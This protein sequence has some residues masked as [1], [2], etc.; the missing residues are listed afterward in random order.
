MD[1]NVVLR[2][3]DHVLHAVFLPVDID[4]LHDR[5]WR[6]QDYV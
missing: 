2:N 1:S 3:L 6:K 4:G 5:R